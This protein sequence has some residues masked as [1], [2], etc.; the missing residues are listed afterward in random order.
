[1]N[2]MFIDIGTLRLLNILI[3]SIGAQGRRAKVI[4]TLDKSLPK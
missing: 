4:N 3:K 2:S 1:M